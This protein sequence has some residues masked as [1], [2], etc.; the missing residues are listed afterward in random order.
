MMSIAS[1]AQDLTKV[2]NADRRY[3]L[4]Q[5]YAFN[6]VRL[7]RLDTTCGE[8]AA[9]NFKSKAN[10]TTYSIITGCPEIPQQERFFGR[11]SVTYYKSGNIVRF[12]MIDHKSGN[13]WQLAKD[14]SVPVTQAQ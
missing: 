8:I 7:Y 2:E 9:I 6:N 14:G 5:E 10:E 12:M 3:V 4:I 1:Y 13:M 11:F